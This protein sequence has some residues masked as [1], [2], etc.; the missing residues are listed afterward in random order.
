MSYCRRARLPLA[1]SCVQR[2]RVWNSSVDALVKRLR[3][4]LH[5]LTPSPSG[6]GW[7]RSEYLDLLPDESTLR[8]AAVL[9]GVRENADEPSVLLTVR[10]AG[11]R[12]HAGQVSFPGGSIDPDDVDPVAAALREANEEIGL[13]QE[14]TQPLGYLDPLDTI[15]GFHVYP[16]V[17]LIDADFVATLDPR[18]VSD[19]FEVPLSYLLDARSVQTMSREFAG[20]MR[21]YHQF[22]FEPQRI[23]GATAT[24]LVN[25]RQ[26]L[27]AVA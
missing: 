16:V 7:N 15:T 21:S 11:L 1:S 26:R 23:W 18:E 10:H 8:D 12:Q 25:L 9:I 20:R 4:A 13:Q 24:M 22:D 27:D 17:A 14:Q 5:P 2:G 6:A 19:L 3:L